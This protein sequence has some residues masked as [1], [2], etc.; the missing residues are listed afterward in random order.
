[1]SVDE[2][3]FDVSV[4]EVLLLDDVPLLSLP[5]VE[6]LLSLP[7]VEAPPLVAAAPLPLDAVSAV[8]I[9]VYTDFPPATSAACTSAENGSTTNMW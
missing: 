7:L 6:L 2:L 3:E 8:P 1:M 5:L 4:A 9:A